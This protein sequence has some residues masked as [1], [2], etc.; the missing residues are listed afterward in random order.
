RWHTRSKRDWSSDVCSSDL[1]QEQLEKRILTFPEVD[2]VFAQI[3]TADIAT[4]PMP[5][6]IADVIIIL[7]PKSEWPNPRRSKANLVEAMGHSLDELPGKNYEFTQPIEMRLNELISDLRF[8]L[9]IRSI[10]AEL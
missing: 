7:K 1:M 6:N 5:P 10:S 2:K 4:D 3:G 8:A 9:C